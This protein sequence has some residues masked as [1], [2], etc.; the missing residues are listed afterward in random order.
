MVLER[1]GAP[2]MTSI[3]LFGLSRKEESACS[4]T[5][6]G[7]I[8]GTALGGDVGGQPGDGAICWIR[9]REVGSASRCCVVQYINRLLDCPNW[10]EQSKGLPRRS[11]LLGGG[12]FG[13]RGERE[14]CGNG[15]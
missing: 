5:G 2:G 7:C 1:V 10:V 12:F 13:W 9:N 15:M 11:R 6:L 8:E 14:I 3:G 4:R